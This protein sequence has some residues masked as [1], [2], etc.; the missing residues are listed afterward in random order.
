MALR[1]RQLTGPLIVHSDKVVASAAY[2]RVL[3]EHGL[4][5]SLSRAG[6][7]YDNA[8]IGSFWSSL[9]YDLVYH[10]RFA[11]QTEA[12][13]APAAASAG[14]MSR[15]DTTSREGRLK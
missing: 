14:G 6:T 9:K 5:A 11:T 1:Q 8:V 4:L 10:H 15:R 12:R 3:A 2:R 13:T 7:C